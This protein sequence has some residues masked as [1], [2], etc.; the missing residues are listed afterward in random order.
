MFCVPDHA[1]LSASP[2]ILSAFHLILLASPLILPA[3][4]LHPP[5]RFDPSLVHR[6]FSTGGT[7]IRLFFMPFVV[8]RRFVPAILPFPALPLHGSPSTSHPPR[9]TPNLAVPSL[10]PPITAHYLSK[11]IRVHPRLS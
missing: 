10:S 2:L 3:Y 9:P 5:Q 6:S 8:Y 4:S 7:P 1:P 11:T